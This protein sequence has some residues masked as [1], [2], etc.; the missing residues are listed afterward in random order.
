MIGKIEVVLGKM[1]QD[2]AGFQLFLVGVGWIR[3]LPIPQSAQTFEEMLAGYPLG[4]YSAFRTFAH[5]KF[6]YLEAHLARLHQSISLLG[7]EYQFD[8]APLREALHQVCTAY[9]LPEARVRVD[10]L[11][12]PLILPETSGRLLISLMPFTSPPEAYYREG[13]RVDVVSGLH[14]EK[15]QAKTAV[16]AQHRRQYQK[17]SDVYEYLMLADDG[18]ILEGLTSNF[19]AVKDGVLRTAGSGILEGITRKIILN[20]AGELGIPIQLNAVHMDDIAHLQEAMISSSSRAV[21]PVVQMG[22]QKVGDGRPGPVY[23]RLLTAYNQFVAREVKTAIMRD[24]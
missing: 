21:L 3:P 5:N 7:W 16:F 18:R 20:L 22:G 15:P 2:R 4:V 13:I 14:R 6:L 12:E 10:V 9:P 11:A 8:E 17:S 24:A 23:R 1:M 19:Y